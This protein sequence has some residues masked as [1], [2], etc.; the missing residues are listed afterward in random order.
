MNTLAMAAACMLLAAETAKK[1][2]PPADTSTTLAKS[3]GGRV[4]ADGQTAPAGADQLKNWLAEN[5]QAAELARKGPDDP[6]T[7]N[8]L[9]VFK[10]AAAR[11]P[12]TVWFF[13]K[14]DPKNIVDQCSSENEAA[15]VVSKGTCDLDPDHGFNKGRS[16]LVKVGQIIKGKFQPYAAGEV[17]LK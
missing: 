17:K 3:Y 9:A 8:Y 14:T 5:K 11:G 4:W 12:M 16:Y 10:K 6:W 2:P 15:S 13:D 1:E 7:L